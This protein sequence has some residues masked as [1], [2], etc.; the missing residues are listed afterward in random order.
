SPPH[1][2]SV[3]QTRLP[4]FKTLV[5]RAMLRQLSR[6]EVL[7]ILAAQYEL[8]VKTS[9]HSPDFID[10]HLHVH[11]L[12]V[13]MDVLIDFVQ[14]L[15]FGQRPY[16]RNSWMAMAELRRQG[17]PWL[18]AMLIGVFGARLNKK[19]REHDLAT[20]IG[21]AGIYDFNKWAEYPQLFPKFAACLQAPNGIL[22]THPGFDDDWRRCEFGTLQSF[23]GRPNRFIYG[24]ATSA[25]PFP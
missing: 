25:I 17:L 11:Q 5:R 10:S 12:P 13:V 3:T 15:P 8:F 21:F 24:T 16:I 19:L 20:N 1:S 2:A 18:K 14:R 23:H 22:V 9:G 4:E 7:E 6:Q